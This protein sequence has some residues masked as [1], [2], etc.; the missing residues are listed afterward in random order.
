[1]KA[2]E[3][4]ACGDLQLETSYSMSSGFFIFIY[5]S[6]YTLYFVFQ[7]V[8]FTMGEE[9]EPKEASKKKVLSGEEISKQLDRLLQ[10]KA[11]N[12]RIRDWI[13]VC[14]RQYRMF[15]DLN[16]LCV[17]LFS[18]VVHVPSLQLRFVFYFQANLDEQQTAS[19]QFVR[20]LMTS[21]C[22]SAI[23]CKYD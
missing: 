1:M 15:S 6:F 11:N 21:V 2:K 4:F 3:I 13:E 9:M 23:I 22:Q 10:D 8:E 7:K 16:T 17:L 14:V 18:S 20:A 5:L 19:N 12:Q